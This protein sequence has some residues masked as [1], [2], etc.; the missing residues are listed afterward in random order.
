MKFAEEK[1]SVDSSAML[2][3]RHL[4]QEE[5][6]DRDG[7]KQHNAE[8]ARCIATRWQN[9]FLVVSNLLLILQP[10]SRVGCK[11]LFVQWS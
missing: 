9:Y 3:L 1:K 10:V 6:L 8:G 2:R 4:F 5:L 7:H 11:G